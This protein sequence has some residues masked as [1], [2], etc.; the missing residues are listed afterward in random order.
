MGKAI[1]EDPMIPTSPNNQLN[2]KIDIEANNSN[3][4][5]ENDYTGMNHE[6]HNSKEE[7]DFQVEESHICSLL[8]GIT[9]RIISS[10]TTITISFL[11]VDDI[12][13]AFKIGIFEFFAKI[14][15][16]YVHERIW[17]KIRI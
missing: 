16:Y 1:I 5:S 17:S 2:E 3:E 4:S 8:K 7:E 6:C 15:I 10:L 9:Y 12:S 11:I 13:A 14:L